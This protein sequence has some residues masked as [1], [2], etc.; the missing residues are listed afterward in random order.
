MKQKHLRLL[1]ALIL[2]YTSAY[3]QKMV[4]DSSFGTNGIASIRVDYEGWVN[5]NSIVVQD[6]KLLFVANEYDYFYYAAG[7]VHRLTSNGM[8]DSSF[9]SNGQLRTGGSYN[10]TIGKLLKQP[11]GKLLVLSRESV[12]G[13]DLNV[14]TLWLQR[15]LP[16]GT[17]DS[18]FGTN[19]IVYFHKE[20]AIASANKM[21]VKPDGHIVVVYGV[22]EG[23]GEYNQYITQ[24]THDGVVDKH[25]GKH[26]RITSQS[27]Y[28]KNIEDILALP[29]HKLLATS[30]YQRADQTW[31]SCLIRY[32]RGGRID[33][34][35]GVNGVLETNTVSSTAR[36]LLLRSQKNG[37]LLIYATDNGND[38]LM[39]YNEDATVDNTFG[40]N[41]KAI[42]GATGTF[43][44]NPDVD[45]QA[46]LRI[47][48]TMTTGNFL[49]RF[50]P[51]GTVDSTFGTDGIL[52]Y[53]AIGVGG[54]SFKSYKNGLIITAEN[55]DNSNRIATIKVAVFKPKNASALLG[56]GDIITSNMLLLQENTMRA[57]EPGIHAYPNPV[58][59]TLTING[60]HSNAVNRLTL[61]NAAGKVIKSAVT[62][63]TAYH[64]NMAPLPAGVYFVRVIQD[65]GLPMTIKIIKH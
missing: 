57:K 40:L 3:S 33:S 2:F 55:F 60:L 25:F 9:A 22:R 24:L 23:S 46:N 13:D 15:F 39:R 61:T 10:S 28:D 42:I 16:E 59:T 26:G 51:E 31:G 50:M 30:N 45:V 29:N 18:S 5:M 36:P 43:N 27:Q 17:L 63:N 64:W 41:G 48:A 37:K 52:D 8:P 47:V 49:K 53:S 34:T 12:R 20:D 7:R 14:D 32:N 44:I 35:F 65:N 58:T 6:N 54:A 56:E 1:A 62:Q 11:D 21:I 38:I 19:G 4:P